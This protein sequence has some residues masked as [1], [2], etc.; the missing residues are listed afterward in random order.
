MSGNYPSESTEKQKKNRLI[1]IHIL[2][3]WGNRKKYEKES[4]IG[5]KHLK[6]ALV[7]IFLRFSS[8]EKALR[9]GV[10]SGKLP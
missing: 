8:K 6:Y 9:K 7:Q 2:T 1:K 3:G 10:R 5:R 4:G